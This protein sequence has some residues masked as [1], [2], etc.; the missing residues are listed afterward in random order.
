MEYHQIIINDKTNYANMQKFVE[1]IAA[2]NWDSVHNAIDAQ[3]KYDQ[4]ILTYTKHYYIKT[5]HF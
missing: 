5:M 4:F 3:S 2:E 1:Y